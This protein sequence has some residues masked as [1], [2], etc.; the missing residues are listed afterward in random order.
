MTESRGV[1]SRSHTDK[2]MSIAVSLERANKNA[3]DLQALGADGK[4]LQHDPRAVGAPIKEKVKNVIDAMEP[5]TE[6]RNVSANT[7]NVMLVVK[8]DT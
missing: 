4:M 7:K 8:W 5:H 1:R 6:Q 2:A 3:Q